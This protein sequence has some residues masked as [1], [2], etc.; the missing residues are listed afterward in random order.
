MGRRANG[1][2]TQ[3]LPYHI[4]LNTL[5]EKPIYRQSTREGST[6]KNA[7]WIVRWRGTHSC[8]LLIRIYASNPS[9]STAGH[10]TIEQNNF[11][12][13]KHKDYDRTDKSLRK[14]QERKPGGRFEGGRPGNN[15][16]KPTALLLEQLVAMETNWVKS[17]D[18]SYV[19]VVSAWG[20][21]AAL[22]VNFS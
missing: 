20:V 13:S 18:S 9:E 2:S 19:G 22:S 11:N 1:W 7:E 21:Y 5:A 14:K 6:D 8:S 17:F 3:N 10:P 12:N 4:F 16:E 15:V